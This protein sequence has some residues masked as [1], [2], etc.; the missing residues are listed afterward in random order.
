MRQTTRTVI[1]GALAALAA[2][3]AGTATLAQSGGL[4]DIARPRVNGPEVA[5]YMLEQ[6]QNAEQLDGESASRVYGG[7]KSQAGAWP[8]QV[9]M[10]AQFPPPEGKTEPV[11]SQF[12]G[13]SIIARQWILTAA[14]CIVQPD[15]STLAP[16]KLFVETGTTKLAQGD[17]R[18]V[19]RIITHPQYDPVLFD[20]DIA[21]VKLAEPIG[22]SRGAVGAVQVLPQGAP[23]PGGQGLVMGW[24]M[25]DGDRFTDD[26]METDIDLLPNDT[27]NRGMAEQTKRDMGSF[28]LSMG[29]T[30]RIP[31][32]TLEQAFEILTRN[33]GPALTD[34]MVCAGVASGARTSCRGDSG[35][36]LLMRKPDGGW[37]Q[38]GVVSWGRVPI[39]ATKA[40]GHENLYAVYTRVS[41]YFDWIGA[42]L[43]SN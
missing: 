20:N 17:L 37:I 39:G 15:G 14:H 22:N 31:E 34:N 40:C 30:S 41:N 36:P 7:R 33:I 16:D 10:V 26:L 13:G 43:R 8:F 11:L 9:A 42:Q 21:L 29:R 24:G 1:A 12:C 4:S 38:V 27:C 2:G 19:A 25:I 6:R 5:T 3:F 35:G 23:V 32:Q 28:L 18:A